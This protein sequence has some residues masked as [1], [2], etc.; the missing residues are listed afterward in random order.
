MRE[1]VWPDAVTAPPRACPDSIRPIEAS[2]DQDT[3]HEGS[4]SAVALAADW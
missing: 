4:E 1:R 2:S 3:W